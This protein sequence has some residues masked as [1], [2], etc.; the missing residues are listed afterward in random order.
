[1]V[2]IDAAVIA[3]RDSF[4]IPPDDQR[5]CVIHDDGAS[6]VSASQDRF[7]I[8]LVDAYDESGVAPSLANSWFFHHAFRCLTSDGVLIMNMH[9]TP[10]A[11]SAHLDQARSAF[12]GRALLVPVPSRDNALLCAL[13]KEAPLPAAKQLF[14]RARYLQSKMPLNFRSYLQRLREEGRVL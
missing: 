13:A 8:I 1:V 3:L 14:V 9:G 11:F 5:F 12:A 10:A 7:E 4:H 6:Y 2:E